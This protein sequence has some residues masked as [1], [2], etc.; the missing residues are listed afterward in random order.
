[1]NAEACYLRGQCGGRGEERSAKGGSGQGGQQRSGARTLDKAARHTAPASGCRAGRY[2][3]PEDAATGSAG[4]SAPS[5]ASV[6]RGQREGGFGAPH[7]LP[8]SPHSPAHAA[9]EQGQAEP[10]PKGTATAVFTAQESR[11]QQA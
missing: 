3:Y 4:R 8:G 11:G 1:M 7:V 5:R 9:L 6:C 2:A 10:G